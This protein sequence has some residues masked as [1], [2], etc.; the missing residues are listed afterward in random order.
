MRKLFFCS[1]V[2][3]MITI[4]GDSLTGNRFG[5]SYT[6]YLSGNYSFRG[7]DGQDT[8]QV[9]RRAAG[10]I[11]RNPGETVVLEAGGNDIIEIC[12][13]WGCLPLRKPEDGSFEEFQDWGLRTSVQK[14]TVAFLEKEGF[15]GILNPVL[16]RADEYAKAIKGLGAPVLVCAVTVITEKTDGLFNRL[17]REWNNVLKASVGEEAWIDLN[18]PLLPLCKGDSSFL[19]GDVTELLSDRKLIDGTEQKAAE[20]SRKRGLGATV[21]GIHLNEEGARAICFTFEQKIGRL[22]QKTVQAQQE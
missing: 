15:E 10:F 18:T 5:I 1:I 22:E 17:V 20:L 21:D 9:I 16:E 13:K 14:H 11:S 12:R 4:F 8:Q 6:R 19:G 3:S 2:L 7:I